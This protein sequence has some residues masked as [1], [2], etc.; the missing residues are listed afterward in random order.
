[1]EIIEL[2]CDGCGKKFKRKK[3]EIRMGQ[4]RFYHSRRCYRKTG[5]PAVKSWGSFETYSRVKTD[6]ERLKKMGCRMIPVPDKDG[7]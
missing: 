5:G 2:K 3:S 1:M 6:P 7:D 4:E